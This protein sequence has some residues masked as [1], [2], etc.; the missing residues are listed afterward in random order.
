MGQTAVADGNK[1]HPVPYIEQ[2][3]TDV[4]ADPLIQY[5]SKEKLQKLVSHNRKAMEDA[6]KSLDFLEAARL[7]DELKAL[8]EMMKNV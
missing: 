5:L 2:E 4:A 8:Q 3:K 7:R 1:P 6:V